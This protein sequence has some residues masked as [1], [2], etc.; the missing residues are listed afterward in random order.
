MNTRRFWIVLGLFLYAILTSAQEQ[1][2]VQSFSPQGTV[3]SVRQVRVRFSEPM[4]AFGNP[5]AVSPFNVTCPEKG[6]GRWVDAENWAYDFDRDLPAGIR[7]EFTLRDDLKSLSGNALAGQRRFQ[8]SSGGPS[9]DRST[10]FQG[11]ESISDDQIF[12]LELN[13]PALESSILSNAYFSVQGISE[14]VGIRIVTGKEREAI[15]DTQY[16]K[17]YPGKRP[18]NLIL[19]QAKQ[20]FPARSQVNLVWGKGILTPGGIATDQDQVLSFKTTL[21]F[22]ATFHCQRENAK[23]QCVPVNAMRLSFT[24][25]VP[26]RTAK[27]IVLKGPG[28]RIWHPQGETEEEDSSKSSDQAVMGVTFKPPFPEKSTLTIEIPAE[29]EDESGHK[30]TNASNFPLTVR[31]DDYPPLAK[32]AADFGILELKSDPALPVTLRNIEPELAGKI[33]EA[34]EGEDDFDPIPVT[35]TMRLGRVDNSGSMSGSLSGRILRVSPDKANQMLAWIRKI[36][37]REYQDRSNSIFGPLTA[38]KAK[39]FKLPKPNG[40]KP[41]EVVGIPLKEPGFYVVE[42]E[43]EILGAA[44]LGIPKPMY[45]PTT[46]LVTNLSVHLKWG[47]ESSLIWV[48]TLDKA[49]PV[50][51]AK[52]EVRDCRGKLLWQG[53]T[54]GDGTARVS[55]LPE[56]RDLPLCPGTSFGSGGLLATAQ[57]NEDMAFVHSSWN[58]GIE[59]WRYGVPTGWQPDLRAVHTILDRSL[60]RAG[61]TVHMKHI[62]RRKNL[63]GFA[64]ESPGKGFQTAVIQH[65]G[66]DQTYEFPLNWDAAGIAETT[67]SI[68]KEARLGEYQISLQTLP[69]K[70]RDGRRRYNDLASRGQ[71]SGSFRIEEFR[72][73]SMRAIIRPPAGQVVSPSTIPID[74]TVSY[75]SGGGASNLPVKFRYVLKPHYSGGFEGFDNYTFS[76]GAVKEGLSRDNF[77]EEENQSESVLKSS[78]LTLDKSGSARTAISGLPVIDTPMQIVAELEFR[79]ANGEV[80]TASS[81]I[82]LWPAGR[83]IG[84]QP[85]SWMSKDSFRFKVAVLDLNRKPVANAPVNVSLFQRKR[86]SHRKRLVGGFYAYENYSEVKRLGSVCDGKTDNKGLLTCAKPA[87]VSGELILQASTKDEA[88]RQAVANRSIWIAGDNDWWFAARDDDRIDLLPEKKHYEPGQKA[89][90]QLRMPFRK[91]TALVTIEREGV[92][93]VYVKEISGKEPVIEIPVKGSYAPNVFVSVL[94]VRGRVSNTQPTATVDL[95]RPAYKMGISEINVGWK[96]H[97]LKVNVSTDRPQYMV[98]EKAKVQIAVTTPEGAPPPKSA[99]VAVAAVDEGLLELKPNNSWQVLDAM[100]GR[101]A[102]SVQTSTAQMHVIGKRHFG[103]KALPQ[104]GGGGSQITR[105]LFDTLLLWKGRVPLDDK[106]LA[107]VEVPINDSITSFRIVAVATAGVDRFG[108]GSTS[109]RSTRDL[110]LLSG[111]PPVVRQGDRFRSTFTLRNTTERA[112]NVRVITNVSGIPQP[113]EP[114][115]IP[116]GSGE[117]K[118]I[119]WDLT[120]PAGVDSLRYQVEASAEGGVSDRLSVTQRIAPAVPVRTFQATLTQVSGD[121]RLDVERPKDALPGSGGIDV[122]LK[123]RLVEG[124]T[125]VSDYMS[126]YPYTC[127]EQ[128]VSKAVAQRDK[129]QWSRIAAEMPAHMDSEGLLKYFPVMNKGSDVLTSYV[130]SLSGH[131]G[132][133]IPA[134]IK[135]RLIA[136]LRG[137]VE[138]RIVRYS[139]LPT[140][141]LSVRK[142]S[143]VEA[144][145]TAEPVDADLLSSITIEP[146]LW[147]TSA[148]IDWLEILPKVPALRN[149]DSRQR[150]AEQI[151]RARL[152]FQG[153]TMNFSTERGDCLWWLMISPDENAV[154]LILNVLDSPDWKSDIPRLVRGA[155]ARQKRGHWDTTVANAWGVLAMD[156]FSNRFEQVPVTGSSSISLAGSSQNLNWSEF[157]QGK[158]FSFPW[159]PQPSTLA[160]HMSGTGRPWATVRSL[161]AIPL[162][163]PLSSGFKIKKTMTPVEQRERGGWSRG[164]LMRVRLEVEAQSDMTWVVVT[165]PIPAGSTILGSGLGRDSQ[166]ATRGEKQEGWVWPAFEERSFEAFRAYYEFVPKGTWT[167]EYTVRLNNEGTMNLPPSRVEAMYSPEMFGELPNQPVRIQ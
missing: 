4:V 151:L 12:V 105:E 81:S 61:E 44:L 79:D 94:V 167:I 157:S 75:L 16:P 55:A 139:A 7:C 20:R 49:E 102:Y 146:N 128:V 145:S 48:T 135:G 27:N 68:P 87:T 96:A 114:Q 59:N 35:P 131:A 14:R 99:E 85:D 13:G 78:E 142:L 98:R 21:P 10:P 125:G 31:T 46:V 110:I 160:L 58:E 119:F 118:N 93:D 3:K 23:A 141:D 163:E 154:R 37:N 45:V 147:P 53:A 112:L 161:A 70:D 80:Q 121:Y 127:L 66:S 36:S 33:F 28:G 67:W 97:E 26:W 144:L 73:P 148:L 123:P 153:T 166:L 74:L 84:I 2:Q 69:E 32:F 115:T 129:A 62:L 65:L 42:I 140:V 39:S 100:M 90:F 77:E 38:P 108:T 116:L 43:S 104:G 57:L 25:D 155:L 15:L 72:V 47:L 126:R 143:A 113:L 24:A 152:N 136:G 5:S 29:I 34:H 22:A 122:A 6:T 95:G 165:D 137:F 91:A 150:E 8:L 9:I 19:I 107:T 120:A 130:L 56:E 109:I 111:I 76:N 159:P 64:F 164:D 133:E 89:R 83:L 11:T 60:L 106:G 1:A 158:T 54:D 52:L 117:S 156:K 162:K 63:A 30:L 86:Y 82:P 40:G 17:H 149:R 92:G 132:F 88:G 134:Q 103:L 124:M 41:F 138:G 18:E 51:Q 101:R 71:M 50:K